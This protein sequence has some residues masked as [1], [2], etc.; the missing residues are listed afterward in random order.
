MA[1][2]DYYPSKSDPFLFIKKAADGEPISFAIIYADDGGIIGTPDAIKELISALGKVFKIKTMGEMEKFVGCH[3]IDTIDKD[4]VWIHQPNILNN[5]KENFKKI[6]GDT[7]RIYTTPSAPKTLIIP[8]KEGDPLVTPKDRSNSEWELKCYYIW[9][10]IHALISPIQSESYQR[11]LT[12]QL[13]HTSRLYY[14]L[15]NMA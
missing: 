12:V 10:N 8:P 1:T 6:L 7:K 13:K 5:L 14:A 3:I 15:S 2:C 9:L 11:L 4:G